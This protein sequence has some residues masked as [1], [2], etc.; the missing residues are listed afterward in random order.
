MSN[1]SDNESIVKKFSIPFFDFEKSKEDAMQYYKNFCTVNK[2]LD[3]E[4]LK[5][6]ASEKLINT[7][8]KKTANIGFILC[9][10]SIFPFIEFF[11][12]L[13]N[14]PI[15]L[16]IL[17]RYNM[18]LMVKLAVINDYPLD[19]DDFVDT[20]IKSAKNHDIGGIVWRF[21]LRLTGSIPFIGQIIS[22]SI[23]GFICAYINKK[24][25]MKFGK[26]ILK[27]YNLDYDIKNTETPFKTF[28]KIAPWVII[29][30][31]I[32]FIY[33]NMIKNNGV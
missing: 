13:G 16:A 25:T 15:E 31:L 11:F 5:Y 24:E 33:F 3:K 28:L 19:D 27:E 1:Y 12:S 10:F 21:F 8:A 17:T 14:I 20:I 7:Y 29:I 6:L 4:T 2:D 18:H 30:V 26:I 32:L 23:G 22:I 9:L